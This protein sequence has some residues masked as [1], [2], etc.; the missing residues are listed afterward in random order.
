MSR[1]GLGMWALA[2]TGIAAACGSGAGS[3]SGEPSGSGTGTGSGAASGSG[4]SGS[5][6]ATSSSSGSGAGE[7]CTKNSDCASGQCLLGHCQPGCG[8]ACKGT[9][10]GSDC[11]ADLMSDLNHCGKCDSACPT[12]DNVAVACKAG[13]CTIGACNQGFFDCDGDMANGCESAVPCLCKPGAMQSCYPGPPNTQGVGACKAGTQQCNKAGT[14]WGLCAGFVVPVS[15]Q[16]FC[17]NMIDDDC[18]GKVDD[19]ITDIDGDGWTACD[20]D[21]CENMADCSAPKLVNPGA[22]DVPGNMVDDDCNGKVDDQPTCATAQKFGGVTADDM[23]VAMDICQKTTA[24]PPLAQKIWGLIA[25]EYRTPAGAVPVAAQLTAHQDKQTAILAKYGSG[26]VVPQKGTT[27]GGI[28]SGMMRATGDPGYVAPNGGTTIGYNQ[29]PPAVYLAQHGNALP[30]SAGCSGNCPAGNGANDGVNLRMSIRVPTNALSFSYQF[31][32]FSA[33]YWTWHCT[34]YN[35]FYLALLTSGAANIPKDHNIS[36]DAKNNPVSVNNGFFQICTKVSCYTCPSG[37][38]QL[39]GTG[40]EIGNTGG[41]TEWLKTTAPIVPGETMV[42]EL[43]VFD[44]SDNI[45]DSLALLDAFD[46]SVN[47]SLVGT[48]PPG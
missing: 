23:A 17:N 11:V 25:A 40:M 12:P 7:A 19:G 36:F 31:R 4:T 28:S 14:A 44:V 48:G 26:G 30:A 42:L 24:N 9:C 18:N 37:A 6:G 3:L 34:N 5:G 15:E 41:G 45:L 13:V 8:A 39:A 35:D 43:M 1:L 20:G 2:L 46:W 27:M 29:Q 10:C 21:C 33:E 47:A 22:Y 38:G 16:L 32:F